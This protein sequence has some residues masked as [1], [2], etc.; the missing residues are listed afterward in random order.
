[1]PKIMRS[2]KI[3][4][5]SGVDRPAQAGARA[6][7]M[8]RAAD[9]PVEEFAKVAFQQAFDE[10]MFDRKFCQ[11]FYEA[12]DGK[13]AADE[14]FQQALKDGYNNSED[15]VRQYVE[16][17]AEMARRAAEATRGL[18]KSEP[19]A[20]GE[21]ARRTLIIKAVGDAVDEFLE[22]QQEETGMFKYTTKAALK[23]AIT[24][25]AKGEGTDQDKVDIQTSAIALGEAGLLVD[26]LA[27]ASPAPVVNTEVET[28]KR[29]VA[30]L[31]LDPVAKAHHD[32]L[33]E[34]DRPAF[35]AKSADDQRAEIDKAAELE[36][37]DPIAYTC[38]DGTVIRKSDGNVA[39]MM[40]KRFDQ[41]DERLG[42]IE[43]TNEGDRYAKQAA[44]E[45]SALP[46]EGTVA[47]LKAAEKEP[48]EKK[49]KAML[50]TLRAAQKA[51]GSRFQRIGGGA[52]APSTVGKSAEAGTAEDRL[53]EMAKAY[54][55]D[56]GVPFAKAY[57]AVM[58]TDE[59]EQ[60]YRQ[61]IEDDRFPVE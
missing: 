57:D 4:E 40:A 46:E 54:A 21:A 59:G 11:V 33:P 43:S 55:S 1:M 19:G 18:A 41:I 14:A 29:Q 28:L 56:H 37:G 31:S 47:L 44:A 32:K 34:A 58:R 24:K 7:I 9:D 60:L 16:A 48:D 3:R 2:L 13:W 45:F 39:L 27:V 8:K 22:S 53:D 49:R 30:V 25:F 36:K 20:A 50:D 23:A 6:V 10:T 15:T 51:A 42:H 35:L 17:I 52:T 26:D 5:I 12:F 61:T 38:K